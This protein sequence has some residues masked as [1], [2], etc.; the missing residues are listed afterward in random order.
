MQAF[1]RL[2]STPRSPFDAEMEIK[3][4]SAYRSALRSNVRALW[5][6]TWNWLEFFEGM[7]DAIRV[8]YPFAWREGMKLAGMEPEAMTD[9]E[10]ARLNLE[11]HRE[12]RY[13]GRFGDAIEKG[14][15]ANKGKLEPLMRRADLWA[16]GYNRVRDLA[17][18]YA[19]NDPKL[20]WQID[21]PKESCPSCK[22]LNGK[23]KRASFWQAK[24][25]Y[26][27]CFECLIC[28]GG[29]KCSFV[30][31]TEPLSRGPLPNLP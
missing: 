13:I 1:R 31:T 11:I 10:T 6:G 5:N 15:K 27:R 16:A 24:G 8:Q 28:K 18:T 4:F 19:K 22:K 7:S 17:M 23:I 12:T 26:P 30:P 14:S 3:S 20:K 2:A 21:A 25:I 29:C 9:D